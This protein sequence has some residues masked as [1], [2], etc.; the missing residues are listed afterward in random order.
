VSTPEFITLPEEKSRVGD[1]EIDTVIGKNH[2]QGIVTIV[3]RH[4]KFTLMK[5]VSSKHA[6][7]V[8]KATLELMKPIK[9]HTLTITSDNGKEFA[10][11]KVISKALETD[12][13]FAT[14]SGTYSAA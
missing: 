11:H 3:D 13:Y 2:H 6:H 7:E 1:W 14:I 9:R 10:Y 12:F 4:S 5:K 8:T